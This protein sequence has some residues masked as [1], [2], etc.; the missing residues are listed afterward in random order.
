MT[1]HEGRSVVVLRFGSGKHAAYMKVPPGHLALV[2]RADALPPELRACAAKLSR[3]QGPI[4]VGT[5]RLMSE[6]A[7]R[8]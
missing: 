2:R 4:S 5:R 7:R 6:L 3:F 1:R 8:S